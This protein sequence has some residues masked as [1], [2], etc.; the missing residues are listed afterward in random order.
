MNISV[1]LRSSNFASSKSKLHV[2]YVQVCS[3]YSTV[4]YKHFSPHDVEV[5]RNSHLRDGIYDVLQTAFLLLL[6]V[7]YL[8]SPFERCRDYYTHCC[9]EKLQWKKRA[10]TIASHIRWPGGAT[11]PN[12]YAVAEV[13]IAVTLWIDVGEFVRLATIFCR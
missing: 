6:S 10:G 1:T 3:P 13:G 2:V 7:L 9:R 4:D 11:I 5:R 12:S 8:G